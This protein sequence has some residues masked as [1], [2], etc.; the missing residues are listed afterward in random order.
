MA[1]EFV[2]VLYV[3][4]ITGPRDAAR[5]AIVAEQRAKSAIA[6]S[7]TANAGHRRARST[8]AEIAKTK[9]NCKKNQPAKIPAAYKV[10]DATPPHH[11]RGRGYNC[12]FGRRSCTSPES[13]N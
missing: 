10:V 6:T 12:L 4:T 2:T 3:A 5:A 9:A 11:C 7:I 1:G 8:Y 13:F